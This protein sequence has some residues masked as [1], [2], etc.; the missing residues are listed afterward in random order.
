MIRSAHHQPQAA[1]LKPQVK[2]ASWL[3][4]QG[5]GLLTKAAGGRV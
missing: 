2:D 5:F 3:R 1:S 4:A